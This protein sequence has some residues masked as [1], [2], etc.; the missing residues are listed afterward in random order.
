MAPILPAKVSCLLTLSFGYDSYSDDYKVVMAIQ[1][2]FDESLPR[3]LCNG[4][5]HWYVFHNAYKVIL[6]FD[7]SW[8]EFTVFPEPNDKRYDSSFTTLGMLE[9]QLCIFP[10]D[11]PNGNEL[12]C[13]IWV[14]R[15]YNVQDSWE[16]LSNDCE[17]N[18]EVIHY[19]NMLDCFSPKKM[20]TSFFCNH[21]NKFSSTASKYI[22]APKFV[23]SLVYLV[24][25]LTG[26][27]RQPKNNK[28][29]EM[30]SAEV[31]PVEGVGFDY[32]LPTPYPPIGIG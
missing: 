27:P 24:Y 4:A 12:P 8:E 18:Y 20:M 15:N 6:S 21:N 5:L 3:I 17:I 19:M 1:K 32:I 29:M 7:L 31:F 11:I 10:L 22:S 25:V 28:S 14:M 13:D 30:W 26:R 2:D 23:S 16:L 9:D